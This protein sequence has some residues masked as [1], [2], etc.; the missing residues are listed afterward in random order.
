[1]TK[2]PPIQEETNKSENAYIV[3]NL[4]IKYILEPTTISI[5]VITIINF[6]NPNLSIKKPQMNLE[7]PLIR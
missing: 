5:I 3:L 6:L 2:D 1:M 4:T 7:N